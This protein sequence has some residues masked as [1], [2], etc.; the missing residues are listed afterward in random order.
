MLTQVMQTFQLRRQRLN[1]LPDAIQEAAQDVFHLQTEVHQ[2]LQALR[3]CRM[4]AKRIRC[5]GDYHLGQVLYTGKDFII[6][7]FEGEPTPPLSVR[8]MKRSPLQ[9]VAGIRSGEGLLR[10]W[11]RT[12]LSPRL[13]VYTSS[14]PHACTGWWRRNRCRRF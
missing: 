5:H 13:G 7:D 11:L 10:T 4:T 9:D 12:Q 8:R 14:G 6:I 1:Y 3:D 2:R